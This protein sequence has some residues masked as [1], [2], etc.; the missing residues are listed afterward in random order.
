MIK[1]FLFLKMTKVTLVYCNIANNDY[2]QISGVLYTF[3]P[4]RL[5]SKLI[6]ISPSMNY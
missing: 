5:F 6:E 4:N 2:Q 1:W 3:F